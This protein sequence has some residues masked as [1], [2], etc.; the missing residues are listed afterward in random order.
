MSLLIYKTMGEFGDWNA[1]APTGSQERFP[2]TF[3]SKAVKGWSCS[4]EAKKVG[5][6]NSVEATGIYEIFD[7][8]NSSY[9]STASICLAC[10]TFPVTIEYFLNPSLSLL[11]EPIDL[12]IYEIP[13]SQAFEKACDTTCGQQSAGGVSLMI[14]ST[15]PYPQRP[16]GL[17]S[18]LC[19]VL[20]ATP[21]IVG[22]Q[23]VSKDPLLPIMM[24]NWPTH[25]LLP[26]TIL[27]SIFTG[28]IFLCYRRREK[29]QKGT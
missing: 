11:Q 19:T 29:C 3:R 25:I 8:K 22:F 24:V 12:P 23:E 1:T 16:V 9:P 18:C 21:V 27:I 5:C 14:P 13:D 17:G 20:G 4:S 10:S 26:A 15:L 28:L 7:S 6:D 2:D